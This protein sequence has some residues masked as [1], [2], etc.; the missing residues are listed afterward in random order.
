MLFDAA[1]MS[2]KNALEP[3]RETALANFTFAKGSNL[4]KKRFVSAGPAHL[5]SS[6][7]E[8]EGDHHRKNPEHS[9]APSL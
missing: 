1:S 2:L 9:S 4:E 7:G 5:P 6:H 8:I 3:K